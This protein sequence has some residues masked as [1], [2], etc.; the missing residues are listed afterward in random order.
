[1]SSEY[2]LKTDCK[3]HT[4]FKYACGPQAISGMFDYLK[5]NFKW[6]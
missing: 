5:T 1:M 3:T 2:G 4:A 6:L